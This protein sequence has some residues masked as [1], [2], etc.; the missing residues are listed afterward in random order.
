MQLVGNQRNLN[1]QGRQRVSILAIREDGY[2]C[3]A[4]EIAIKQS[5]VNSTGVLRPYNGDPKATLEERMLYLKGFQVPLGRQDE[6]FDLSSASKAEII[7]YVEATYDVTLDKRLNVNELRQKA[8]ETIAH[9][10]ANSAAAKNAMAT[11]LAAGVA[12]AGI[13]AK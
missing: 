5:V 7:E 12:A 13:R 6:K 4:N 3:M 1:G 2:L 10:A 9:A 8:L 11:D